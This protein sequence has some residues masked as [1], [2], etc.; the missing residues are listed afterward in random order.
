MRVGDGHDQLED[1]L[2][3]LAV[4]RERG[5]RAEQA[6]ERPVGRGLAEYAEH[7]GAGGAVVGHQ[8]PAVEDP[9]ASVGQ[10][11]LA[12]SG[13]GSGCSEAVGTGRSGMGCRGS[14][15]EP[16]SGAAART[17]SGRRPARGCRRPRTDRPRPPPRPAAGRW[18]AA[19]GPARGRCCP[20]A[21]SRSQRRAQGLVDGLEHL[22]ACFAFFQPTKAV[23]WEPPFAGSWGA[24][25]GGHCCGQLEA[26]TPRVVLPAQQPGPEGHRPGGVPGTAHPAPGRGADRPAARDR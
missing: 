26:P 17:A 20:A 12:G 10:R 9:V 23:S 22:C 1:R 18:P 7:A 16:R 13:S 2:G 11:Q 15:T 4:P 19:P 24:G 25:S 6:V 8:H 21:E 3:R 14:S 5:R